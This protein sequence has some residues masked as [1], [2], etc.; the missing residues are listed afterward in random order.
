M[1]L[2]ISAQVNIDSLL[3]VWNDPNQPDTIRLQAIHKLAKDGYLYSKPDSAFYFAQ[4][5][6]DFA[7]S[8]GLKKQM[9]S[10]LNIQ[11]ASFWVQSNY[12]KAIDYY[13][14]SLVISEE[15]GD[16]NGIT[17]ALNNIGIVLFDQGNYP[18]AI[19]HY[20]N[21]LAISEEIGDKNGITNSLNNIGIIYK[22]W[23]DYTKAIDYYTRSL[24]INEEIENKRGIAASLNN[25]GIV[26]KNQGVYS[27]AI[28]YYTRSLAISE[29]IGYYKGISACLNNIGD[30]YSEQS[31][32]TSAI[33]YYTRSL[34]INKEIGFKNGISSC[35][36]KIGD[37]H[38]KQ[39]DYAN[40]INYHSNSLTIRKEIGDQKGI[41]QSLNSFGLIYNELGNYTSGI[42]Y[43][44]RS[45]RIAQ[46]LGAIAETR[47]AANALY[48]SFKAKGRN[49]LALTMY[50]LYNSTRDSIDSEEN[51]REV[52]RQEYKYTYE[53]KAA[54]D[55][56]ANLKQQKIQELKLQKS[57]T[58]R[59]ALGGGLILLFVFL[60]LLY[61]R[62]RI[63]KKQKTTILL[64]NSEIESSFSKLK[65]TQSQLI[66][67]E[68][69]ASLGV[70]TTGIAH[71]INNPVNFISVGTN[72]LSKDYKAILQIVEAQ[73]ELLEEYDSKE[74]KHKY[75][76]ELKKTN[77]F[78][79]LLQSIPQTIEDINEGVHRTAE[80]ING[81]KI[82]AHPDTEELINAD[83]HLG[84]ESTVLLLNSKFVHRIEVITDF[85]NSLGR[86]KCHL[87]K[88]NQVFMNLLDN[89]ITAIE[90]EGTITIKTRVKE[91]QLFISFADSGEGI[92]QDILPKIFDPFFTTREIGFGTGLGLS[93]CAGII[94]NHKGTIEVISEVGKGTEFVIMLPTNL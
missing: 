60:V 52:I 81:L 74:E 44:S 86:I 2:G 94:A 91:Q 35:L 51:Q 79:D 90:G 4:L 75:I 67:S 87:G 82:Y 84:I 33:D 15:I 19:D 63:I 8:K 9:I 16:K 58:Q 36:N 40:A 56:I 70:L 23:G 31:N 92:A 41:A 18:S 17:N 78:E 38:I 12:A 83:I 49:K 69:M 28:D 1:S 55:S 27:K 20:T 85:D 88:L 10:A 21:S 66:Q 5:Q 65:S 32:Y 71:E 68:K 72:N 11:G 50:E 26:Y 73:N 93:I 53:K 46:E 89:A 57:N 42:K 7:K 39:G 62:Y 29:E 24:I 76:R 13:T 61:G 59:Y 77:Y 6:Y 80:I 43:N 25:I 48:K 14:Q 47:N 30:I 22:N 3:V 54:I 34:A 64:Q 45:L 37:I